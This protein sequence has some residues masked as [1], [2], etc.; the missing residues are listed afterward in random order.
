MVKMTRITRKTT[1]VTLDLPPDL[2]CK[3]CMTQIGKVK[4]R[5]KITTTCHRPFDKMYSS[6]RELGKVQQY[7]KIMEYLGVQGTNGELVDTRMYGGNRPCQLDFVQADSIDS[8]DLGKVST[9]RDFQ[10]RDN[11]L[12]SSREEVNNKMKHELEGKLKKLES[13]LRK[14]FNNY[15]KLLEEKINFN[16][17]TGTPLVVQE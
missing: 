12:S 11:S 3:K 7:K 15:I 1:F 16:N 10:H 5:C 6:H 4:D 17:T 8:G 14:V 13:R 9:C 2:V